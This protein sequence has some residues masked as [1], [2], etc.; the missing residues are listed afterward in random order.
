M[1]L[2]SSSEQRPLFVNFQELATDTELGSLA[3]QQATQLGRPATRAK[4]LLLQTIRALSLDG[5]LHLYD[6]KS[7]TYLLVSRTGVLEPYVRLFSSKKWEDAVARAKLQR[8][9]PVFLRSVP[10]ARI[11]L[12]RRTL[13]VT[14]KDGSTSSDKGSQ[15]I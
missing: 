10:K 12:V 2:T 1:G 13:E 8:N 14:E 6:C 5:I 15:A 9:K 11:Q 3:Q 4:Q 7:D